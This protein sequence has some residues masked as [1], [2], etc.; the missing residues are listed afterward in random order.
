MMQIKQ[1]LQDDLHKLV[2]GLKNGKCYSIL[3]RVNAYTYDME[4][5]TKHIK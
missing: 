1:S 5:W 4:T 2:N 3:G